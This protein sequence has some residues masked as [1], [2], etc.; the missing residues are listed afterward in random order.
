MKGG[1]VPDVIGTAKLTQAVTL[2]PY[3]EHLV[4]E[5]LSVNTPISDGSAVLIDAPR[6]Q[7]HKN[8][9]VGRAV[10]TMSGD[11]RVPVKIINPSDKWMEK[12]YVLARKFGSPQAIF[13]PLASLVEEHFTVIDLETLASQPELNQKIQA[14]LVWVD[15]AFLN[16]S[17]FQVLPNLKVVVNGGV[18][19]D[20]LDI[21][22]INSFGVKVCNTPK[23]VD[24]ATADLAMGLMLASARNIIQ[25]DSFS[26]CHEEGEDVDVNHLGIDV[27]SKTL[28]IV[29]MGSIGYKV[30][31]RA[32]AFDMKIFYHNR[33]RRPVE[34]EQM[35]GAEYC[36]VLE[37]LLAVSDYVVLLV[38]LTK[39]STHLIGRKQ[40]SAMKSTATLINVSRGMVVDQEALVEALQNKIIKAAA[41]D[42]TYPEPL[43]R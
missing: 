42:V 6:S 23:V 5:R 30:A 25:G 35:V 22:L 11:S 4:W 1:V 15:S 21:P 32:A 17:L 43:P 36:P 12:P 26:R 41:L 13:T 31:K 9:M 28:G 7:S 29:G 20:H 8:I 19:V 33:R 34:E 3:H 40:L 39:A 18:G 37:D 24:N 16:R 2:L 14:V 10:A 27:G 38:N